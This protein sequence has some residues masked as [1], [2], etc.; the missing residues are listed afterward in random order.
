MKIAVYC[1]SS[2]KISEKYRKIAFELGMWLAANGH[3]LVSGGA[4]GGLM[5][6]VSDGVLSGNGQIIGVI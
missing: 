3:T 6:S 5:D 4:T 1:S 2:E